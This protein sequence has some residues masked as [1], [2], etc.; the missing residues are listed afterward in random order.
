MNLKP[1]LLALA[2]AASF[3]SSAQAAIFT[4]T[5]TLSNTDPTFNRPFEDLSG[6][7]AVGNAVRYDVLNFV[8][9]TSGNYTF[10]TTAMFDSFS[11]L[12]SPTFTAA[13]PLTNARAA[14][15]DLL[16]LTTSGFDFD[17]T[18]GTNYFLVTTSFSNG[19]L[20]AYSTTIGGPGV[21]TVV[22]EAGTYGMMALGLA[23]LGI[24]RRRATSRA[25]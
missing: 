5:G 9:G 15:D 25:A 13:A 8:V 12:Y 17:L 10:L 20:G 6:L 21:I 11:L 4:T 2:A 19:E 16:G 24:A 22:P 7:S 23:V 3:V 14:N 1:T 18:A